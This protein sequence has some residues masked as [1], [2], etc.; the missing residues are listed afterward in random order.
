[1]AEESTSVTALLPQANSACE[2]EVAMLRPLWG[3]TMHYMC[4]RLKFLQS[5]HYQWALFPFKQKA[6]VYKQHS[7]AALLSDTEN[8][9]HD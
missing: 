1:M 4:I 8:V 5:C 7:M 6:L 3:P 2:S 9:D